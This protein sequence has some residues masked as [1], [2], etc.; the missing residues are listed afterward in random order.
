MDIPEYGIGSSVIDLSVAPTRCFKTQH[1]LPCW[2]R[3]VDDGVDL[4]T[5]SDCS[6]VPA[7]RLCGGV[8]AG[9]PGCLITWP[10]ALFIN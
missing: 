7:P 10:E 9:L 5:G 4:Q 1:R 3:V 2:I 6:V 8:S